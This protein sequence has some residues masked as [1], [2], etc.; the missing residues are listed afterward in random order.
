MR[1]IRTGVFFA[2]VLLISMLTGCSLER[3]DVVV[4]FLTGDAELLTI[5]ETACPVSYAK[6][7][8]CNYQNIYGKAYGL[9]L[10]K[11]D[12]GDQ[13]L[14]AYVKEVSLTELSRVLSMDELART[15]EISLSEQEQADAAA[16]AAEYFAT[17]NDAEK[18]YMEIDEEGLTTLYQDY[19]LA[20]KLYNTLTEGVNY[21]VSEDEARVM[22][23]QMIYV[24]DAESAAL[25]GAALSEGTDFATLAAQ[26]TKQAQVEMNIKR[27]DLPA[28]A[29]TVAYALDTDETGGPVET[30]EGWYFI[31]C[32]DKNVEELT[33]ENKLVIAQEREKEASDDVYEAFVNELPSTLNQDLWDAVT[34]DT[35]GAITTNR[36]FEIYDTYF[37]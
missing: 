33:A 17:L 25:I 23:I 4:S 36:F 31:K 16:A 18:D 20:Q 35:G 3:G 10:W 30:E 8:L 26:Y 13:D 21:E 15:R 37:Q 11:H 29:E 7:F 12:F 32:V 24:E 14:E 27:G 9:D 28:A 1:R 34:L 22:T 6:V 2:G 19:A 5:G